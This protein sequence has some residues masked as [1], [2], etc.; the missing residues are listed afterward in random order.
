MWASVAAMLPGAVLV[1]WSLGRLLYR[2]CLL[3]FELAPLRFNSLD[4]LLD[5]PLEASDFGVGLASCLA[6]LWGDSCVD[7]L[8]QSCN[9]L[10]R[11]GL[12]ES[13]EG[14][15]VVRLRL[16]RNSLV[17]SRKCFVMVKG[18]LPDFDPD[19]IDLGLQLGCFSSSILA[20]RSF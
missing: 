14:G 16:A 9:A 10:F 17:V 15:V 1:A 7:C 12:R 13:S 4:N 3:V 18:R 8:R 20:R 2:R 6:Q 11:S 5:F 19:F